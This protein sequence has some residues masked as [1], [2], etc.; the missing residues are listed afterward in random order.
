MDSSSSVL[1]ACVRRRRDA[2]ARGGSALAEQV[3]QPLLLE[4]L[5]Q[6]FDLR[7][8]IMFFAS[9]KRKSGKTKIG[10]NTTAA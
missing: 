1:Q 2:R 6:R 10:N 9:G 4:A 8:A 5:H 3:Q 7:G